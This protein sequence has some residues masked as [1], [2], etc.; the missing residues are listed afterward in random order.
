[1]KIHNLI[2]SAF[3]LLI[4]PAS[5]C[6]ASFDCGKA[7][8][9]VEK[10]I[11]GDAALS[12]LDDALNEAYLKALERPDDK[13]QTIQSQK[14]WLKNERNK[15]RDGQCLKKTYGTRIRELG[16][17]ASNDEYV[18]VMSK[19]DCVC[20]H[21]L[22]IYNDD[23]KEYGE[24]SY[25]QHEEFKAIKWE[26]HKIYFE[27]GEFPLKED[28]ILISKFD[29]N[30]DGKPEII[31]KYGHRTLSGWDSDALYIFREKDFADFKDKIV[32]NESFFKKAIGVW[33]VDVDNNPFRANVYRLHDLPAFY[34]LGGW[35]YFY[36][37]VYQG[38]YFTSMHDWLPDVGKWW[39]TEYEKSVKE[40]WEVILRFTPENQLEDL[41]YLLKISDCKNKDK[42][43]N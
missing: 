18:L 6:A 20:Q 28:D 41:C 26:K 17:S 2:L 13:E 40:K 25:D 31:I 34:A 10:I 14:W 38:K 33:G 12:K 22:E 15:C 36:P 16:S 19:D 37:F 1:M 11:C 3:F 5:A 8:S 30:N 32:I 7:T 43:A 35:F 23:L 4:I 21:M 29:I 9:E 27:P 42:R 24:I 39:D